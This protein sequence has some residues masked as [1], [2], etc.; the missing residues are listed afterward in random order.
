MLDPRAEHRDRTGGGVRVNRFILYNQEWGR[1][2]SG[3]NQAGGSEPGR[4]EV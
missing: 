4:L 1:L 2:E 3:A